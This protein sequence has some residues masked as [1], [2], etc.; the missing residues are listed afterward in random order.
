MLHDE[1]KRPL[2][3]LW[4]KSGGQLNS[5]TSIFL[6]EKETV[7]VEY[8]NILLFWCCVGDTDQ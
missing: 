5:H 3:R 1:L 7:E 6:N 4:G 8:V 2:S